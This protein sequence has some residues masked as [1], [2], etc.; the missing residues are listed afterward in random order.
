MSTDN[1]IKQRLYDIETPAPVGMWDAI[2]ARLDAEDA[3][4]SIAPVYVIPKRTNWLKIALAASFIGFVAMTALWFT[5]SNGK[6][7]EKEGET[8]TKTNTIVLKDTVYLPNTNGAKNTID[9]VIVQNNS[10][11]NTPSKQIISTKEPVIKDNIIT[12]K[13]DILLKKDNELV[14]N[15]TIKNNNEIELPQVIIKDQNGNPIKDINV[16]K[17][18]DQNSMTG[19]D[20][21]GDKSIGNVINKISLKTDNEEIDSIINNSMYW[22]KQITEWRKILI[23]S[24][25]A[26]SSVNY[27]D[28][29]ELKK[30]IDQK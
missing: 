5:K 16:I 29:L 19:P 2:S 21:K 28:I 27:L 8:I 10:N 14:T 11:T 20:N 23:K 13:K 22:K 9:Q 1:N 18:T 7:I 12:T 15:G 17:S 30:L 24:G 25:Y 6:I 26:P 4:K 3:S